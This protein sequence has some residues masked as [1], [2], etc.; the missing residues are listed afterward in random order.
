MVKN[1]ITNKAR[2]NYSSFFSTVYVAENVQGFRKFY[3]Y[4]TPYLR[5]HVIGRGNM[6]GYGKPIAGDG[7]VFLFSH[8]Q[9][10]VHEN[11]KLGS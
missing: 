10:L 11:H 8:P 5:L 2:H 3:I 7:G 9:P 4:F 6:I 1:R